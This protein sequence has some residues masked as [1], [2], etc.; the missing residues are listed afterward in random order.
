MVHLPE[1]ITNNTR[2]ISALQIECN[3]GIQKNAR[4]NS[5]HAHKI[6]REDEEY[7]N[8]CEW[9]TRALRIAWEAEEHRKP[10]RNTH[11]RLH[12]NG[13]R[14]ETRVRLRINPCSLPSAV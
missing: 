4:E 10:R 3:K 13:Q 8:E 14:K 6:G 9:N 2:L 7:K 12:I 5:M 1:V 11:A